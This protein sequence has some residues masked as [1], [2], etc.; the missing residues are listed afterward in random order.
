MIQIYK[1]GKFKKYPN[2]SKIKKGDIFR[3][4]R[5]GTLPWSSW[6]RAKTNARWQFPLH[7]CFSPK[8]KMEWCV[9]SVFY[10]GPQIKVPFEHFVRLVVYSNGLTNSKLM[11]RCLKCKAAGNPQDEAWQARSSF[12]TLRGTRCKIK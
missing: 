11:A 6:F 5:R 8:R 9:D 7:T 3:T 2:P 1:N 12:R 4:N 10:H